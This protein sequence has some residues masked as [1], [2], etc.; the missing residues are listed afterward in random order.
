[1]RKFYTSESV[2]EGHPDKLAD[3]IS[4][5]ILD[6][7]LR[8]EPGSRVAVETLVTTG[9]AVVAGEVRAETAHVDIQKTVRE[10][11]KTGGLH[12]RQLRLRCRVQRRAGR[13]FMSSRPRLRIGVDHSEEWRDMT[14]A[15]GPDPRTP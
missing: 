4:D 14:P 11:V 13:P 9:M 10:A 3:F 8:L 7:F 15:S 1:M 5:A 12:P 2:S 6:E